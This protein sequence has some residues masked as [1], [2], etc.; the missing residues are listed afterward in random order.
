MEGVTGEQ[1]SLQF[2]FFQSEAANPQAAP[3]LLMADFQT[4]KT[5][6]LHCGLSLVPLSKRKFRLGG[7]L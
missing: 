4:Q 6:M 1:C 7:I 2:N 3:A 5:H